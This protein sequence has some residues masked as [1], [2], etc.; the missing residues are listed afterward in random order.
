MVRP[1]P[2]APPAL[3]PRS[4]AFLHPRVTEGGRMCTGHPGAHAQ[5]SCCQRPGAKLPTRRTRR[6]LSSSLWSWWKSNEPGVLA[7]SALISPAPEGPACLFAA[8]APVP[9]GLL[10]LFPGRP[11][12]VQTRCTEEALTAL[13]ESTRPSVRTALRTRPWAKEAQ[14]Q[15]ESLGVRGQLPPAG[16]TGRPPCVP[17]CPGPGVDKSQCD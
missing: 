2:L 3:P 1:R 7:P 17:A 9:P 13:R 11:A 4:L 5:A 6:C 8:V 15:G 16:A 12:A 10:S 14:P